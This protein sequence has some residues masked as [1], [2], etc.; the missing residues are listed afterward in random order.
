MWE[1]LAVVMKRELS[2]QA[3]LSMYRQSAFQPS[4][5]ASDQKNETADTSGWN[6]FPLQGGWVHP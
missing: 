1:L 4:A 3:K 2:L 5:F 6:D